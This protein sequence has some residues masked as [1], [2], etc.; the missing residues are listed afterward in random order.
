MEGNVEMV[1][2]DHK[3]DSGQGRGQDRAQQHLQDI[4]IVSVDTP[5]VFVADLFR[6]TFD[7]ALPQ[8]P[9]HYVAFC[10][11]GPSQFE[12]IGYYHVTECGPYGLVGGLCVD[13]RYRNRGLGEAFSR[14]ALVN[15]GPKKALFAYLGNPVSIAIACRVGYVHTRHQYLMVCWLERVPES[16]QQHMIDE[17]AARGPF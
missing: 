7:A 9:T 5:D 3:Q 4:S 10:K 2:Q 12:A 16:E 6:Q 17:V 11:T 8:D 15:P 14:I 1:E 13:T